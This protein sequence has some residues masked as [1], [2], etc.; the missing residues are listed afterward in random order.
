MSIYL[1][2]S[3][4]ISLAL[5]VAASLGG[6]IGAPGITLPAVL[7]E[8][9]RSEAITSDQP[10]E[11]EAATKFTRSKFLPALAVT[12][13]R[14]EKDPRW[15]TLGLPDGL[16]EL[17]VEAMPL[18][19]F[20]HVALGDV[21]GLSF[22]VDAEVAER[23]DAVTLRVSKAVTAR[24]ML[25]MVE[26]VM[27]A[28]GVGLAWEDGS[29]RVLPA[30]T[31]LKMPPS[32]VADIDGVRSVQ[33]QA[34]TIIPLHYANPAEVLNFV[35]HFIQ[36]GQDGD[37][38]TLER[39]N[40]L[41]VIGK[42]SSIERFKSAVSM[43]DRPAMAG[44][45]LQLIRTVYWQPSDIAP[46]LRDA[47]AL[48][49]IAVASTAGS[50]GVFVNPIEQLNAV[51]V[52]APN[53]ETI[54]W[55]GDW[56]EQL[57]TP[58][59]AGESLK[60]FVYRVKHSTA[61]ELGGVLAAV[62]GGV[63]DGIVDGGAARNARSGEA[64][65]A[66]V[67]ANNRSPGVYASVGGGELGGAP[68]RMV[69]D[70]PHNALVFIGSA[71]EYRTA[72]RLLQQLDVPAKQVLLEVT[73]ADV[74]LDKTN[75]LGVE[76]QYR[77]SNLNAA[78]NPDFLASTGG[79]GLGAA[80]L[81]LTA[82]DSRNFVRAQLNALAA[83]GDARILSS[84]KLL[85][86]DNEEA[87]IQ[88]GTQIAV[89]KGEIADA[90][91]STDAGVIRSFEYIDTGVIL[92]FTPTVMANGVVRLNIY[93]EVSAPGA[94]NNNTPPISKRTI[95]TTLV[96]ESGQTVMLGGLITH[97]SSQQDTQVPFF[98]DIPLLGN[99]FRNRQASDNS[100]EMIIMITPHVIETSLQAVELTK[101]YRS[102]L[103]L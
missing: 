47:L 52:A 7:P 72:Y 75:Q 8:P 23:Q 24:R 59:V 96:A 37:V 26:Q 81:T 64:I 85:A 42:V 32:P 77:S 98:G 79:L 41:L 29:L 93:Q 12:R 60:N 31:L 48:Q 45:N 65:T 5:L 4:R 67:A 92:Q 35:R 51:L 54:T 9:P 10:L 25:G 83:K 86:V 13:W 62:I 103:D 87:R 100:T 97:N 88:V 78:G 33:G 1:V 61:E 101:S 99:L 73:I 14:E 91:S 15:E 69:I 53:K 11:D 66:G 6:C 102:Q 27:A 58:E 76:W 40:A 22:D 21:L 90:T 39:L 63:A 71:R 38:Q 17:N 16:F 20:I 84:P 46:L 82:I 36:I 28:Y 94:S 2:K 80:G 18:S 49:G 19:Q 3:R 55:I 44:Q 34:M 50:P 95:E 89:I 57:D 70:E 56:V 43:V 74:S 30:S 68:L